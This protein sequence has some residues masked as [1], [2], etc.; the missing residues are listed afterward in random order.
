MP[1]SLEDKVAVITGGSAGIGREVALNLAKAGMNI[2][3]A[4]RSL[5][6]LQAV[7]EELR[8]SGVRVLIVPTDISR[9]EDRERLIATTV[10][11]FG[12]IDVLVNNAGIEAFQAFHEIPPEQ[13][14]ATLETNMVGT[15]MLTR[16]AIPHML[17]RPWARIINMSSTSALQAPPFGATYC[18]TK[19]GM[20]QFSLALRLE[21]VGTSLSATA[22]C[23]GFTQDGGIYETIKQEMGRGVP[24]LLRGVTTQDVA[25]AVIKALRHDPP[26][27]IVDRLGLKIFFALS[28]VFPRLGEWFT[29]KVATRFFRKLASKRSATATLAQPSSPSPPPPA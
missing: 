24:W 1:T 13:I 22:I 16:L 15:V 23:P 4:A 10:S 28:F 7:A 17:T 12:G 19:A 20:Y 27:I 11:E 26:R 8:V 18:A 14:L 25:R 6:K 3:L 2:V 29:H 21:Y 5:D 9:Q